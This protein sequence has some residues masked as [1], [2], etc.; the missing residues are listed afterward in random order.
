[1]S[2]RARREQRPR[3]PRVLV[4]GATRGV[5][6][7]V[8]QRLVDEGHVPR[9]G[10]RRVKEARRLLRG[11]LEPVPFDFREPSTWGAALEGVQRLF[12]VRPEGVGSLWPVLRAAKRAGVERVVF[13]SRAEAARNPLERHAR[14]EWQVRLLGMKLTS[15]RVGLLMQNLQRLHGEGLR[16]KGELWLPGGKRQ[17]S[18]VD[19]R[20]VAQVAVRALVEPEQGNP[21]YLLTGSQAHSGQQVAELLTWALGRPVRYRSSPL[22]L[23]WRAGW[24]YSRRTWVLYRSMRWGLAARTSP[25]L[26]RLLGQ[27]PTTLKQ[28]LLDN[29]LHF[30]DEE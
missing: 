30:L 7:E 19:A 1:M 23:L 25:D 17:A 21:R 16:R 15:L 10:L 12:L 11:E 8:A 14:V 22:V 13:L 26:Q 5:G 18:F 4:T 3:E 6:W 27:P 9:V 29:A 20:D 28:Y 24:S 2:A